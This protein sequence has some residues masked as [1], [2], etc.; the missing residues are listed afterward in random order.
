MFS[1]K[2]YEKLPIQT[3]HKECIFYAIDLTMGTS[4]TSY[5]KKNTV[6]KKRKC[7]SH[8]LLFILLLTSMLLLPKQVSAADETVYRDGI[9]CY[10]ITD[11]AKKEVRL[12][13][14][15]YTK[16]MKEL[17]IP[18]KALIN[19]TEYS[20]SEVYFQ[21]VYYNNEIYQEFYQSVEKLKIL[22]TF[23]GTVENPL[24]ALKNINTIELL[25]TNLL[26]KKI[27]TS[28]WNGNKDLDILF[29]VPKGYEKE[30]RNIIDASM[31]YYASS[32]LYERDL[33]MVPTIV[34]SKADAE[35][36]CFSV[37]G[38][39][40]QVTDSAKNGKGKVQ[41][42]GITKALRTDY[43]VLPK[44]V[45]NNGYTYTLTKICRFG[46]VGYMAPV[47]VIPDTVTEMESFFLDISVELL[48]LS[49]NC[50]VIPSGLVADENNESQLRFVY[51]PEGVTT[52]SDYAFN[53]FNRNQSSVI[54]PTTIKSIGEKSL[55][56]INL[57]TFLN[58]K[59]I[60]NIAPAI[61][62]GT[63]VKVQKGA[64]SAYQK[65]LNKGISVVAAKDIVKS[66]EITI[67]KSKITM[68]TLNT[69]TLKGTLTKGSN[70]TIYWLSTNTAIFDIS[71]K[72]VINPKA[73]GTAYVIAYTR[74]SGLQKFIKVTVTD[75]LITEGI[76]T[77]KISD[78]LNKK[79]T[80]CAIK[81]K[82]TTKK[83]NIPEKIT[84]NNK[85]YTVTGVI[86]DSKDSSI[87]LISDK[88]NNNNITEVIFPKTIT[89]NVGYLGFMKNIKSI[90]FKG[91]K[92]PYSIQNWYADGGLLASQAIINVPAKSSSS[93][94][95]AIWT[96]AD[97]DAYY[98]VNY[99][100]GLNFNILEP[101]N[102]Q[103]TQFAVDGILYTVTKKAGTQ[104]GE[105]SIKGADVNLDIIN[106]GNTVKNGKYSYNVTAIKSRAFYCSNAKKII[107][108]DAIT[109]IESKVFNE[110]VEYVKW[111]KS[112]RTIAYGIFTPSWEIESMVYSEQIKF[113]SK[114]DFY[115]LN[116]FIIPNGVT[117]IK[118]TVFEEGFGN[119]KSITIPKSVTSIDKKAFNATTEIKY[120]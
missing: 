59:P 75:K 111:P 69:Y 20:V 70:E 55:N 100:C 39:I 105:V 67:N 26:P 45:K 108:G 56:G 109:K 91:A 37:D 71:S 84:Y 16:A 51:I 104:K 7:F 2:T 30:Y 74:T 18:G 110:K 6:D 33:N 97:Y 117:K 32:D 106:V 114:S 95:A 44:Q 3:F 79:L 62:K 94:N 112:C 4:F 57:V 77:F 15:D 43:A 68:D 65:Q 31:Y 61:K 64:I 14:I 85:T 36:G 29:L 96:T 34:S 11:D 25:G 42:I 107:L 47:V 120:E 113:T 60:S 53:F 78:A 88:Y 54:L 49:K 10:T 82:S 73:A 12:I 116:T 19:G 99:G 40:Y 102:D 103:V 89:G 9:Y 41:L 119:L 66:K 13:G 35:Y 46:L 27:Y 115:A 80:L 81:P 48:F 86:A 23:T 98:T 21:Y 28:V 22:D 38:L 24:Y 17:E 83:V 72:G 90:T 52:I 1:N 92:A 76:F 93:Y 5:H 63:T 118:G 50:K 58:K 8:V 87:P 101:G